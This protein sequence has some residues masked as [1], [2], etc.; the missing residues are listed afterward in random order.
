MPVAPTATAAFSSGQWT[1]TVSVNGLDTNVVLTVDDGAGHTGTS[2]AFD[3]T[4]GPL[5]HFTWDPV[6]SPQYGEVPFGVTV[7]AKYAND[8]T[9]TD[10]TGTTQLSGWVGS[11]SPSGIVISEVSTDPDAV[12][13]TNVSTA[14]VDM[15]GWLVSVYDSTFPS[16]RATVTFPAGS[17]AAPGEVFRLLEY[18]TAPGTYPTFYTGG[19]IDWVA[20]NSVAVLL[21]DDADNV[22]DFMCSGSHV[23]SSILN[24]R[25]VPAAEW[26]GSPVPT[27]TSGSDTYQRVGDGDSNSNGDWVRASS[28]VGT[29]NPGLTMPF[30]SPISV[31]PTTTGSSW[32]VCGRIV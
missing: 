12:E 27:L 5:D 7:T 31:T 24:P 22:V 26:T 32:L 6:A 15:A 20:S 11:G 16:P 1:G 9:V 14:A 3:V 25:A 18:G 21:L 30:V 8:Y 19:N 28:T 17:I 13:F 4:H 2:I 10:F 23:P 29:V